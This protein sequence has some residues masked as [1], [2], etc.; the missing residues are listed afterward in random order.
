MLG[1]STK[2]YQKT[3]QSGLVLLVPSTTFANGNAKIIVLLSGFFLT[4]NGPLGG[5]CD[6]HDRSALLTA[7]IKISPKVY[8]F[9]TAI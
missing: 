1:T 5:A 9:F 7:K 4:Q 8:N 2:G 6:Q 3:G